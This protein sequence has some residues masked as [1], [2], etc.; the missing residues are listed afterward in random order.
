MQ[1]MNEVIKP[2]DQRNRLFICGINAGAC[3]AC[4]LINSIKMTKCAAMHEPYQRLI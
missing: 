3:G 2:D 4:A 1:N